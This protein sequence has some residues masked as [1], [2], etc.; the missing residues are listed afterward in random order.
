MRSVYEAYPAKEKL[1]TQLQSHIKDAF[2][3]EDKYSDMVA[4]VDKFSTTGEQTQDTVD[5][6]K[7]MVL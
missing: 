4:A 5:T 1:A 3:M 2:K 7:V 6:D